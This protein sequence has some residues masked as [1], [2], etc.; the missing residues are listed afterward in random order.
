MKRKAYKS[1]RFGT[2]HQRTL[3]IQN[4]LGKAGH[5]VILSN[6][7]EQAWR[8]LEAGEARFVIL[9]DEADDVKKADLIRRVR[10]SIPPPK[11]S[12]SSNKRGRR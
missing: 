12:R 11:W 4:A 6:S 10:A 3:L 7:A 2:Q 8:L 1:P 5:Y 9:D